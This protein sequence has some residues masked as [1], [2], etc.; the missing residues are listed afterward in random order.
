M[1]EADWLGCADPVRMLEHIR[2]AASGRKLLLVALACCDR[3]AH[4]MTDPRSRAAV[5]FAERHAEVGVA[6]RKGRPAVEKA[7]DAA[8]QE[9]YARLFAVPD[10]DRPA[11][12]VASNAANAAS[13]LLHSDPWYAARYASA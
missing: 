6:R 12:L 4:L 7:A 5:A 1:T 3:I 13:M 10:A 2:R 9:A 8:H 11:C